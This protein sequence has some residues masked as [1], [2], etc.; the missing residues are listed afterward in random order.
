MKRNAM[1]SHVTPS[2][3]SFTIA[4]YHWLLVIV[5]YTTNTIHKSLE[6]T[7]FAVHGYTLFLVEGREDLRHRL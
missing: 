1:T 2:Q 4:A 7:G 3:A 5:L 6:C